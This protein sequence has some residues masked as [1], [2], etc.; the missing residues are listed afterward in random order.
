MTPLAE[1]PLTPPQ[2]V[3]VAGVA[4]PALVVD[5]ARVAFNTARMI[6][7]AG[8]AERLRPHVKTHKMR[9]VVQSQ[10]AAGITRFKCATLAEAQMAA[11]A[12]ASDVLVAYPLVGPQPRR[13]AELAL[14]HSRCRFGVVVDSSDGAEAL[15]AA[16]AAGQVDVWL[17]VDCGMGRTGVAAERAVGLARGLSNAGLAPVGLHVYDGHIKESD[18]A[19]R[20]AAVATAWA[21]MS[22]LRNALSAEL[23]RLLRVVTGGAP[24]FANHARLHDGEL[25]PGTC[26]FWDYG[27]QSRYPELG[28]ATA[29]WLLTRVVSRP[30]ADV[31]TLDAGVKAVASEMP[32]PRLL[33][34]GLEDAEVVWHSEEHLALRASK[35]EG[36]RVGDPVWALPW[37]ICPTVALHAE[38]IVVEGGRVVD[39]W[40]VAARDR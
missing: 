3:D 1:N 20:Q 29:A 31:V 7:L 8:S 15:I 24:T 25:A 37:H 26:A 13:L 33:A 34:V 19:R 6:E 23:G 4:T 27:Y 17:D 22:A 2:L 40:R 21:P 35:A 28:Y 12:G 36:L 10:L 39:R 38:A 5:R 32:W 16:G 30:A 18:P 9:E 14:R 11:E